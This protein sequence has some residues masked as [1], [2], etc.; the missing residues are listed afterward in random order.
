MVVDAERSS[1]L[2]ICLQLVSIV[3]TEMQ[4]ITVSS[5]T[6]LAL[7]LF[8]TVSDAAAAAGDNVTGV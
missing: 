3:E 7:L 2:L 8:A 4:L 5:L 1:D 6:C